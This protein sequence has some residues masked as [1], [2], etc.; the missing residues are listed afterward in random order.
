MVWF[1]LYTT[2]AVYAVLH[3]SLR[4]RLQ[5]TFACGYGYAFPAVYGYTRL[6]AVHVRSAGYA[7]GSM[8]P[9]AVYTPLH[10]FFGYLYRFCS[11]R[12]RLCHTFCSFP[13]TH[14]AVTH[15]L[16]GYGSPVAVTTFTRTLHACTHYAH[17]GLR[18]CGLP[19]VGSV[20]VTARLRCPLRSAFGYGSHAV[21][22]T[23]VY[24]FGYGW[25]Q[26]C[27]SHAVYARTGYGYGYAV[28]GCTP[29]THGCITF[30]R[31][32]YTHTRTDAVIDWITG[33]LL[34]L[35]V[36]WFA[37]TRL[38]LYVTAIHARRLRV[39]LHAF[40]GW[41]ACRTRGS[42]GC[43][44]HA[45]L[46]TYAHT[47]VTFHCL[48]FG[49]YTR[50]LHLPVPVTRFTFIF[51]GYAHAFTA[52]VRVHTHVWITHGCLRSFTF[53]RLVHTR[54]FALV[55][56]RFTTRSCVCWHR[57]VGSA[58]CGSHGYHFTGFTTVPCTHTRFCSSAA[59]YTDYTGYRFGYTHRG[60]APLRFWLR[61]AYA[62]T[63]TYRLDYACVRLLPR[64]RGLFTQL[65]A[66]VRT[67][68]TGYARFTAFTRLRGWFP[69]L[70]HGSR[71]LPVTARWFGYWFT[72]HGCLPVTVYI[73]LPRSRF[74]CGYARSTGSWFWFGSRGCYCCCVTVGL[75][76]T[77]AHLVPVGSCPHHVV[78]ARLHILRHCHTQ[79]HTT[80]VTGYA[81]GYT[82]LPRCYATFTLPFGWFHG[83]LR[84][85]HI[86]QF[87]VCYTHTR[88][89]FA[90]TALH[91][92]TAGLRCRS[93]CTFTYRAHLLQVLH[94]FTYR[95]CHTVY[96]RV[97]FTH[98]LRLRAA[99]RT[100]RTRTHATHWFCCGSAGSLH[101]GSGS[102]W[103]LPHALP[104]HGYTHVHAVLYTVT[105]RLRY[106]GSLP[107]VA[108]AYAFTHLRICRLRLHTRFGLHTH[109]SGCRFVMV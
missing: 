66:Y 89:R 16:R 21:T 58:T 76:H 83:Y 45:R 107:V 53:T 24:T 84:F 14:V 70:L 82:T 86:L 12:Y 63:V 74:C 8:C 7:V 29:V 77:R 105:H 106:L 73:T 85:L 57:A 42:F 90:V 26:F 51:T 102:D 52:F 60:Y 78:T 11:S 88:I 96:A 4:L 39:W 93:R 33:S 56:A 40:Y 31:T 50:L 68:F 23:F 99:L 109:G 30:T 13:V 92:H 94:H 36:G 79:L 20:R 25:L 65:V 87:P 47:L 5:F 6:Y 35:P 34:R 43:G 104:H 27:S 108:H 64:L 95:T 19:L 38:R 72:T 67:R 69:L 80:H 44:Y 59:T 2:F 97:A 91:V 1:T 100:P 28:Y 32:V 98:T 41:V 71:F 22:T 18:S 10:T 3:I 61:I 9:C 101:Y 15:T 75:R 62:F 46:R 17:H 54:L 103:L 49:C 48:R 55:H 81:F 37:R